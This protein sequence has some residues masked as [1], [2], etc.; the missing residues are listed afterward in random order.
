MSVLIRYQ[1]ELLLRSQR[2]LPPFLA[3][4]LLMVIGISAGETLLGALGFAAA[5]LVPV[6]AWYV[7]CTTTAEP[8][9]SRACL[10]AAAGRRRVH[11]AALAAALTAGLTLGLAGLLAVWAVSGEVDANRH[12]Q[13]PVGEALVAGLLATVVCVLLGLLIGALCTRPVLL[14]SQYGIPVSL[15]LATLLL[16]VPG[17][18]ANAVVRALVTA[19]RTARVA[20][21]VAALAGAVVLAAL[22]VAGAAAVAARRSD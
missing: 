1:V 9:A 19:N 3:Y 2:W 22:G 10:A 14:R 11:L 5:V 8:A 21:P 17:S 13:A 16:V 4:A 6:T 18:P 12:A 7:R 20:F 15:G